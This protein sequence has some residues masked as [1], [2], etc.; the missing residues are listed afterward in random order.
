MAEEGPT[1]AGSIKGTLKLDASDWFEKLAAADAAARKLGS[2]D[3]TVRVGAETSGADSKLAATQAAASRLGSSSPKISIDVNA[4]A[5][6]AKLA[7]VEAASRKLALATE[8][9]RLSYLRLD[10]IQGKE[11]AS[12]L[13]VAAA[14]LAASRA[15]ET[16]KNATDRLAAAK[17]ALTAAQLAAASATD[18]EAASEEKAAATHKLS[19]QR[20]Q[21]IAGAI[22]ALI[23]LLAPLAGYAVGV[24][25]ALAGM[26]AAGAL[27]IYGI[28]QAV[29][30]ATVVGAQYSAGLSS[31]KGYL[32]SLGKTAAN[33]M[34]VAF[35]NAISTIR[36]NL[37]DLN[38]QIR[39]FSSILGTA[40]NSIL[41]GV[42]TALR[43][44]NPL[45]VQS[46]QYVAQLA[47]GFESW[48]ADG[49][50]QR[51][52]NFALSQLPIVA[53]TLG[54]LAQAALRIVE[55]FAPI[56]TIVLQG[57]TLLGGAISA[58]PLPVLLDVAAGA[59]A[60]FA[61]FKLWGL[62]APILSAAAKAIG[63]VGLATELA[64][65]PIGW[66][67]AGI[68]AL[69]AILAVSATASGQASE[70][71]SQY[72]EALR[73]D[74]NAIGANVRATAAKALQDQKVLDAAEKI[75][76]STQTVVDATLGDVDA[77][78]K[79]GA[80]LDAILKKN[81]EAL[82]QNGRLTQSQLDQ[83]SA[84]EAVR[85]GID[86][87]N[88][89]IQDEIE[90][91][92]QLSSAVGDSSAAIKTNT[93][94][95]DA[96]KQA[97]DDA[98]K[99]TDEFAKEL[100]GI[101][102]V[103]LEASQ[104]SI[105]YN[106]AVADAAATT[107]QY[108]AGLD[109]TS[110]AGRR[111]KDALNNIAS[112]AIALVSA[113]A[114]AG[115]SAADLTATMQ[116][117]HDKFIDAAVAAGLSRDAAEQLAT[118][119]GLIPKNVSTTYTTS[120]AEAAQKS[121]RDIQAAIDAIQKFVTIRVNTINTNATNPNVGFGLGDGHR[122]GGTI[123]AADGMTVPGAG[124]PHRDTVRSMLAVSEEVISNRMGQASRNR[125]LLKLVN[126]GANA[127]QI[128]DYADS[129]ASRG[130]GQNVTNIT[131]NHTWNVTA[132][133]PNELTQK[134]AMKFN[135]MGAV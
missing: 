57:L 130:S 68:S 80:Q 100:A 53:D 83:G 58:I 72:A 95:V 24:A 112:S 15:E 23:P 6:A 46:A 52:A 8:A 90:S 129:R 122:D 134:V 98:T 5:V 91:S 117:A 13:Q 9:T 96:L 45:F 34:L 27:A 116:T 61:A 81:R 54:S 25:G 18:D 118:Q 86:A 33:T 32:D 7:A 132:N 31:L 71:A 79:L 47:A 36:Q 107:K 76:A 119:Y 82:E 105:A 14:H 114:Q 11:G 41:N 60:G 133:D 3:P 29:K 104:A 49:G 4:A 127:N 10:Q 44:L 37:P 135:T 51:F 124:S 87:Q 113:Q 93:N 55:A 115:S 125:G 73:E 39:T 106:Q 66:I 63:L 56:G 59:A 110:E 12:A 50:L 30:Q 85:S 111:N 78:K 128:A 99:A 84:A 109:E 88:K 64:A 1:T 38:N 101:G 74:N 48:T 120:G 94:L 35:N 40:G 123:G 19:I 121:A 21:L 65:G 26:G 131:H 69:A 67:T 20:W 28:V 77:K 42:I 2:V 62:L 22:A 92:R 17:T 16:E 70:A 103:N 108:G 43:I 89:S 97:T 126:S 102:Q 75:G